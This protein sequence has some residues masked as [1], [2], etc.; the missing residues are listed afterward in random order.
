MEVWFCISGSVVAKSDRGVIPPVGSEVT[1]RM[2]T[3]KKGMEAGTVLT[4]TIS[5]DFPPHYDYAA[6][7]V[8]VD[9]NAWNVQ[10]PHEDAGG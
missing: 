2:E 10:K 3:Y 4:F 1:I 7:V 9:V 6:D 8:Y 5:E